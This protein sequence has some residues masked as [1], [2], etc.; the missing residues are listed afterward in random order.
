MLTVAELA[1]E[2]QQLSAS[3]KHKLLRLLTTDSDASEQDAD[4]MWRQE[5]VR[6]VKAIRNGEAAI[7]A[8]QEDWRE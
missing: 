3:D 2:I 6:R 1:A 5:I 7:R 8:L 4:E